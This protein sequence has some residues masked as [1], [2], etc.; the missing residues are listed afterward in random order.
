MT[1][2]ELNTTQLTAIVANL[3]ELH[4]WELMNSPLLSTLTGRH[5]YYRIAQRAIGNRELLS[6]ALKDLTVGSTYS[7][8][9][10]RTRMREMEVEGYIATVS[11]EDDA[12][13]KHLM[14]TE[15][16]YEAIY[17]HAD[18]VRRIFEKDFLLIEK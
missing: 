12:R 18:Q 11:C 4:E 7:D 9:A 17:R 5:L 3:T 14:P 16:F 8:K 10:L 15:I 6:R 2:K 1:A 13:S